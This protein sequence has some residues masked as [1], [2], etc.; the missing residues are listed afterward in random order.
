MRS[1]HWR[2]ELAEWAAKYGDK[3]VVEFP[4]ATWSQAAWAVERLTTAIHAGLVSHDGDVELATHVA[5]ARCVPVKD[6]RPE[7]GYVLAKDRRGSPRKIDLAVASVLAFE[8]R[9]MAIA[10]GWKPRSRPRIFWL[11]G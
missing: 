1:A 8:A 11:S 4:T 7:L 3:V 9:D 10:D 2:T 6:R 5:N